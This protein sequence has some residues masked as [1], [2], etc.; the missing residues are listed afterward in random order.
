[1]KIGRYK[2]KSRSCMASCGI[3][4]PPPACSRGPHEKAGVIRQ[5]QDA[6]DRATERMFGIAPGKS[7]KAAAAKGG[8]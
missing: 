3:V 7:P 4:A 8:M 5:G 1:M 2:R 6:V